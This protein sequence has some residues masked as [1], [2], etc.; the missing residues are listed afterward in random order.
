MRYQ[1]DK[2]ENDLV[3]LGVNGILHGIGDLSSSLLEA[4]SVIKTEKGDGLD[5]V[6]KHPLSSTS[7]R[8][9]KPD[10]DEVLDGVEERNAKEEMNLG[11]KNI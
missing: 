6:V 4:V 2:T 11:N 8:V 9:H 3:V 10:D 5:H 7:T 1:N